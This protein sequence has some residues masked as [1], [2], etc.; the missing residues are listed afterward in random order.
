MEVYKQKFLEEQWQLIIKED[1]KEIRI[2][3]KKI[4]GKT[5]VLYQNVWID[6]NEFKK[7]NME[8]IKEVFVKSPIARPPPNGYQVCIPFSRKSIA[9]L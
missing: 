3:A 4:N 1:D 6:W 9:W 8:I 7:M 5:S 2:D